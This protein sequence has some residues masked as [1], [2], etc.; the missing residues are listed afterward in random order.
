MLNKPIAEI[1]NDA[2]RDSKGL[3]QHEA[4]K[5]VDN[6]YVGKWVEVDD[7]LQDVSIHDDHITVNFKISDVF[8]DMGLI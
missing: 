3:T 6:R 2:E 7:K 4:N 5:L 1:L 8:H